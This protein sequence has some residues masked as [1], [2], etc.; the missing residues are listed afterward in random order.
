[1][2]GDLE[3]NIVTCTECR[4][5]LRLKN[6]PTPG[7]KIL[8]PKCNS[9]FIIPEPEEVVEEIELETEEEQGPKRTKSKG[10]KR[11]KSGGN[12]PFLIG[13][14]FGAFLLT[15]GLGFGAWKLWPILFGSKHEAA[16][17]TVIKSMNDLSSILE[18]V[19]DDS[20][21]RDAA[22]KINDLGARMKTEVDQL[23]ALPK[24]SKS[25]DDRLKAK[26]ES[27]LNEAKSRMMKA[28][29]NAGLK[30]GREP[31]F[32]NAINQMRTISNRGF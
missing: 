21:A 4:A 19:Q 13:V 26:Y 9:S 20:S 17:Q 27:K 2:S 31:S 6:P 29:M 10:K 24:P 16:L 15:M 7:K 23:K 11:A 28:S 3:N 1:M 30:G 8:C 22:P 5:K 25:E 32:R 14:G 18:T 12:L